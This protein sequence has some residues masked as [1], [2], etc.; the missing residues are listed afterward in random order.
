M[1]RPFGPHR[2]GHGRTRFGLWAP[3]VDAVKIEFRGG[4][5]IPMTRGRG[6]W[7]VADALCG[8]GSRY[9]FR[10]PDGQAVPDPAS[11][12]QDGDVHGW[13]VVTDPD[14]YVWRYDTWQGRPWHETVLYELHPGLMGGFAGIESALPDLAALGVTA[15]ELMPV[16]DFPGARN[17]GYD[18]VLP[19][20][21]DESYGTPG[22]LKHLV[23]AA[24]GRGVSVF[25]DVVYNH[26]GP[27]GNY[28]HAYA[29]A[30]FRQDIQ[31]PWGEAIDFRRREVRDFFIGNAIDWLTEY[32]IDGLRFDA[33]H[34]IKDAGFIDE[35]ARAIRETLPADRQVHLV[36]EN[37]DNIAS[38]LAPGLFDAQ[39]ND[40]LHHCLHVLLTGDA[41]GYY[42]DYADAPAERLARC[43]AEG[44]AYQG[45]AS[46]HR[47]GDPRGEPSAHLPPAAFVGFVQNHDQIGNR[48][49][50]ERLTTLAHP[51]ALRAATLLLLLA[52]HIPLLFMGEDCA[53]TEPFLYFTDHHAD[54]AKAVRDGR[55]REFAGF[56]AFAD[57]ARREAI[58]DPNDPETFARSRP[59]S[60]D[61]PAWRYHQDLLATRAARITPLIPGA[62]SLG[63]RAIG[64]GAVVARWRLGDGST[65]TIAVNLHAGTVTPEPIAGEIISSAGG[66]TAGDLPGRS[67]VAA[68]A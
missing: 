60:R 15:I 40:D 5:T 12:A 65:L 38:H 3:G 59:S 25:L 8:A 56:A 42:E 13:S 1:N 52:P 4:E 50:G 45:E 43:L 67:A 41:E 66:A 64:P 7:F 33:V 30:F 27:D 26:F 23:D 16:A 24:H 9:R 32:R 35:M 2:A 46:R 10:L 61:T 36:L 62:H 21:P 47:D 37:D 53:A 57:P 17:W 31:T 54:L 34:A 48:A 22:D 29:P 6:G 63:A 49:M 18:G 51:D 39:W 44:F 14:A 28:L 19:Y 68:L 58:P 11:R 55:R 20:A